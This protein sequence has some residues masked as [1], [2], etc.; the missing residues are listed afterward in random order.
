MRRSHGVDRLVHECCE[1]TRASWH[2]GC[3]WPSIDDK[4]RDLASYHAQPA[5]L[6]RVAAGAGARRA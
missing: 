3:G 2:P 4:I 1:I 5:D 6:G